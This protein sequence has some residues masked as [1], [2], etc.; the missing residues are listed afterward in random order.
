MLLIVVPACMIHIPCPLALSPH[1]PSAL[2]TGV[3]YHYYDGCAKSPDPQRDAAEWKVIKALVESGLVS[4][5]ESCVLECMH[6]GDVTECSRCRQQ[7][8]I[9][10]VGAR[11]G[12][13]RNKQPRRWQVPW[14][15][16]QQA[17]EQAQQ[18]QQTGE[19]QAQ[20]T[21]QEQQAGA[22]VG[23]AAAAG[24][25]TAAQGAAGAAKGATGQ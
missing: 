25:G 23:G 6:T 4:L 2:A 19:Q 22:V 17:Q 15:A 3:P 21:Q 13:K 24:A 18:Q 16:Q 14:R 11:L 5:G 7:H 8:D 12:C 9:N 20:Q 1:W 10:P